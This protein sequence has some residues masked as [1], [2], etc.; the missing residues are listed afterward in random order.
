MESVLGSVYALW[1]YCDKNEAYFPPQKLI[2]L[3]IFGLFAK[4]SFIYFLLGEIY[5]IHISW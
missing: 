3:H 4:Y 5:E 1:H 2:S